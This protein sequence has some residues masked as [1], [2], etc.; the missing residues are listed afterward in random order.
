MIIHKLW[1]ISSFLLYFIGSFH[2]IKIIIKNQ[3]HHTWN[4]KDKETCKKNIARLPEYSAPEPLT[5]GAE[6]AVATTKLDLWAA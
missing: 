5:D 4:L 2:Q 3:I 6:D 1:G